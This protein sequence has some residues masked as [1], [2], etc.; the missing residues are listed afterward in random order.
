MNFLGTHDTARILTVLGAD[1]KPDTK[2]ERAAY[3]LSP[4]ELKRG[5]AR[6]KLAT[7]ILFAGIVQLSWKLSSR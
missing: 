6:L 5:V 3:R 1:S 4:A 2:T 7:L